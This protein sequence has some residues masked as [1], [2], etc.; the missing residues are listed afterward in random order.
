MT[1]VDLVNGSFSSY[2]GHVK[3]GLGHVL[4][5]VTFRVGLA[6]VGLTLAQVNF[7]SIDF[8]QYTCHAKISNFIENF[9]S[10]IVWVNLDFGSTFGWAYFRC[11]VGYGF[12]TFGPNFKSQVNLPGLDLGVYFMTNILIIRWHKSLL[13]E[14]WEVHHFVDF[15]IFMS[16]LIVYAFVT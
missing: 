12:G 2:T 9:R 5:L 14:G 7:G 13:F 10:G 3:F 4:G 1:W 15:L 11:Q 16:D 8:W 6:W